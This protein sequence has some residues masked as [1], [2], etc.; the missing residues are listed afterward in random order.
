[1]SYQGK[2]SERMVVLL[3]RLRRGRIYLKVATAEVGDSSFRP[4]SRDSIQN[5]RQRRWW[6]DSLSRYERKPVQR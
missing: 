3:T 4:D 1:M 5:D 6:L 2:W